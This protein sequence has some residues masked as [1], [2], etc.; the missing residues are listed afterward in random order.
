[1]NEMDRYFDDLLDRLYDEEN[2]EEIVL[3]NEKGT[4]VAFEQIAIIPRDE[5]VYAILKPVKPMDGVAEDEGLV[6]FIN[7]E[8]QKLELVT[9]DKIIDYVFDVYDSLVAEEGESNE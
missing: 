2:C 1:M 7:D 8:E 3:F 4:E 9:D 5:K 6:F